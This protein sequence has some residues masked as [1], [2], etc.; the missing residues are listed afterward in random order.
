MQQVPSAAR[1]QRQAVRRLVS[2]DEQSVLR[3]CERGPQ[4]GHRGQGRPVGHARCAVQLVE[5]E[6][7]SG[8]PDPA[9][10]GRHFHQSGEL[11]GNQGNAPRGKPQARPGDHRR[12]ARQRPR[13]RALPGGE[14]QRRGRPPGLPGAGQGQAGGQGCGHWLFREQG[15]HRSRGGLQGRGRQAS[16]DADPRHAGFE[17]GH[18][19]HPARDAG[20]AGP[21]PGDGRG[22]S[23]QRPRRTGLHLGHRIGRPRGSGDGR[24]GGRLARGRGGHPVRQA[25]LDFG[26]VPARDR[27]ASRRKRPTSISPENPWTRTSWCP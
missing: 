15:L 6:E 3:R 25:A 8:R 13:P 4:D 2:D 11:G 21:L 24:H 20:H 9:A 10:A 7:R 17:R 18:R 5:A 1:R 22:F 26:A 12:R 14:R 16:A 23:H 27:A 19:G